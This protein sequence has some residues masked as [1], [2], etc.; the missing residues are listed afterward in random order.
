MS[1]AI[2]CAHIAENRSSSSVKI[3]I[4]FTKKRGR[5]D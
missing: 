3:A 2:E 4:T 1:L 5:H